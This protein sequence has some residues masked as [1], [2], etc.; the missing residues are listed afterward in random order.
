M[1][2]SNLTSMIAAERIRDVRMTRPPR[3][4]GAPVRRRRFGR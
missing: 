1:F 2:P 3:I 4:G